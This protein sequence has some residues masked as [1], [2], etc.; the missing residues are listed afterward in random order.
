MEVCFFINSDELLLVFA[1]IAWCRHPDLHR[2][3]YL[4]GIE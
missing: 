3:L 1:L 2:L 4:V